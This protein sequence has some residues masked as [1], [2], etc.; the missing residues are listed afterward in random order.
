MATG[1][2]VVP[3][4]EDLKVSRDGKRFSALDFNFWGVTFAPNNDHFY[5]TLGTGG[6]TY[7]IEGSIGSGEAKVLRQNVE[8]PSLSPDGT[9]IAFKKRFT[10]GVL[11]E[12]QWQLYVLD[13]ATMTEKPLSET[14]SVDDQVEWADNSHVIYF[15]KDQ[16]PPATIRPDIWMT[17]VDSNEPPRRLWKQAFSPAVVNGPGR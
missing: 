9:R 12:A 2:L 3:N 1:Q 7:L 11:Q 13:L 16:G 5:A 17:D 6:Q 10:S 4:L 14:R 15:L 8:C